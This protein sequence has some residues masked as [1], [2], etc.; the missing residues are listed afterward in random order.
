[1][2]ITPAVDWDA[3]TDEAA[4]I[5]S[6]YLA[7]D[8]SNPPGHE[9][10]AARFLARILEREGVGPP[11]YYDAGG[12]GRVSVSARLSGDGSRGTLILLN[13]TDVV[14]VEEQYWDVP[15]FAGEVRDGLIWGRG[16]LDMKSMGVMELVAILLA[17]RL[18]LP[19]KRDIVFLAVADEEAGGEWGIEWL[20]QHH[21]EALEAEFVLNEGG[22]GA[23][24]VLGVRRPAFNC[25]VGEKGPLWLKLTAHGTPGHGSVPHPDNPLDRLVRALGRIMEW[26]RPVTVLPE[27]HRYFDAMHRAGFLPGEP[28]QPNL[29]AL[30]RD[31][32]LMRAVL[33]NTVSLTTAR[34]GIK[35]N[36]IPAQAE[37]TIDCRLL[38]GT[39]AEAFTDRV[40]E[41]I[42]DP[43][44]VVERVYESSTPSSPAQTALYDVIEDVVRDHL[45]EAVV[46]PA[47]SPGFTD[48]RVF[49]QRGVT[50]YGFVPVILELGDAATIHGHNE[51][52]SVANLRLG[53]Q[54]LFEVVR[55][56]CT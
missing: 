53:C 9:E 37:A 34:A 46:L 30:A 11:V 44:V 39:D 19:L 10:A 41:V 38:P 45:E 52:I 48:S 16:A 13:H 24:E 1:M 3:V 50:A 22:W 35:H 47:I 14:P 36:V 7:I 18:R 6:R 55:R 43:R 31:N 21:P 8:T 25:S 27:L 29:E 40:R 28:T 23:A 33:S 4:D 32:L 51:R 26:Q 17:K 49:R 54:I 15:P 56:L 42:D 12:E 20:E 2:T 5:L